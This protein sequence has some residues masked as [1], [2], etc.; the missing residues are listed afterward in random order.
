VETRHL[1]ISEIERNLQLAERKPASRTLRD[2]LALI[3]RHRRLVTRVFLGI[4]AG[5]VL[6]ALL[7]APSYESEMKILVKHERVDPLVSAQPTAPAQPSRGLLTE[8]ELNSEVELMQSLDLLEKVVVST[9]LDQQQGGWFR[10]LLTRKDHAHKVATAV[11]SLHENLTIESLKDTNVISV[12]YRSSDP[13][14]AA[15]VLQTWANHYL[16]KHSSVHRPPGQFQFFEQKAEEY[17]EKL[18]QAELR[19]AEFS[20]NPGAVS[21]HLQRDAALGKLSEFEAGLQHTRAAIAETKNRIADL[22][23]QAAV[24]PVRLTTAVRTE[25]NARLLQELK[26]RLLALELQRTELLTKYAPSYRL[27]QEVENKIALTV[28]AMHAAEKNPLQDETTDRDPTYDWLRGELAKA[29]SDLTALEARASASTR[30]INLYREHSRQLNERDVAQQ[31]LLREKRASEENY[32]LYL[33]KREEARITDEMDKSRILNVAVAE[34]P[35]VPILPAN[36]RW[37]L[38]LLGV[39]LAA[40]LSVA[41]AFV[42]DYLDPSFRTPEEVSGILEVPVLAAIPLGA[43]ATRALLLESE[44]KGA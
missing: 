6:A 10:R 27:V 44:G 5:T 34:K 40:G 43:F 33:R 12:K 30:I 16:E 23:K 2:F 8:E 29:R 37:W 21:P 19:L 18:K 36:S 11:Q 42:V 4:L 26:S 39:F 15:Q 28:T 35:S 20:R 14:L 32:L 9:G 22:E 17:R 7:R 3:F 25:S 24:A 13:K 1:A 31:E 41:A 38:F